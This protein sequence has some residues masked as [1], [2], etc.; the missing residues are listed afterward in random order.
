[1]WTQ[2]VTSHNT[3]RFAGVEGAHVIQTFAKN[4][5]LRTMMQSFGSPV[6]QEV[7]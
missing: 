2:L 3:E 5:A 6:A 1:M 7:Q 4:D